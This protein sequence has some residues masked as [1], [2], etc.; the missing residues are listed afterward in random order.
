MKV[1]KACHRPTRATNSAANEAPVIDSMWLW[2]GLNFFF[3]PVSN[4]KFTRVMIGDWAGCSHRTW[5]FIS[6]GQQFAH[7]SAHRA[8]CTPILPFFYPSLPPITLLCITPSEHLNRLLSIIPPHFFLS[9][10]FPS[11]W[12]HQSLLRP[13]ARLI[14][15]SAAGCSWMHLY[16]LAVR[17]RGQAGGY[18]CHDS[19]A[20]TQRSVLNTVAWTGPKGGLDTHT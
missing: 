12:R 20:L 8:Q 3:P 11:E 9:S 16:G 2:N 7:L 13:L 5:L 6:N 19:N 18:I 1:L 15:Q 14:T 10:L 4:N 17:A